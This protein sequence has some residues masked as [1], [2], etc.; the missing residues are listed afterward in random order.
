MTDNSNT[1]EYSAVL[2]R[3]FLIMEVEPPVSFDDGTS[4]ALRAASQFPRALDLALESYDFSY[5]RE[6]ASLQKVDQAAEEI[7]PDPDLIDAWRLPDD[8][9]R[10][11]HVYD[12]KCFRWR[13]DGDLIRT[14][15]RETLTIRY[16]TNSKRLK[17]LRQSF[18]ELVAYHLAHL[19]APRY[20]KSRTKRREIRDELN[21]AAVAARAVDAHTATPHRFDD[22]VYLDWATEAVRG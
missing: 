19:L 16:T 3:A 10:L 6:I 13:L 15:G 17:F 8:F 18:K 9:I 1:R 22:G 20:V 21:D 4:K 5:T 2:E 7:E 11:H 14:E 12:G